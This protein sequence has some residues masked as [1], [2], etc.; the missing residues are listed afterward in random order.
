M[1]DRHCNNCGHDWEVFHVLPV[2]DV[3]EHLY[4]ETSNS[5]FDSVLTNKIKEVRQWIEM[6]TALS[7]IERTVTIYT[8]K[9]NPFDIPFGPIVTLTSV[10]AKTDIN[11]Y[12]VQI[13]NEDYEIENGHFIS[14]TGDWEWKFVF[15]AGYT[16]STM[17]HGL[18]LAFLNEIARRFEHRGDQVIISD[19]NELLWPYKNIEWQM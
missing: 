8:D 9:E 5:D 11:T 7:L 1:K 13:S 4:I 12:E 14:Y 2:N 16:S 3:K 18:K 15:E 6:V 10:S 17:P 19:T